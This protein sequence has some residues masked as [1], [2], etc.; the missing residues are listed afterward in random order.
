VAASI[1]VYGALALLIS[2]RA[3]RTWV[4]VTVWSLAVLL[5]VIVALS[6]LYRGMHHLSDVC[7]GALVGIGALLVALLAARACEAAVRR[8]RTTTTEETS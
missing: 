1:A 2:S 4:T 6:R 5:P 8:R 3:R 7:A